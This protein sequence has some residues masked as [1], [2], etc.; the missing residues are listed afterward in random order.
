MKMDIKNMFEEAYKE[1][2]DA[3]FRFCLIRV[4]SR[5]QAL[6]ITQETFLRFWKSLTAGEKI[7]NNKAFLFTIARR[8]VIDWYRKKKSLSL[9]DMASGEED[10]VPPDEETSE[11][12]LFVGIEGRYILDKIKELPSAYREPLYLRFVE[13]LSPPEIAK[14]LG[15]STNAASVRV[16]RGMMELRKIVTDNNDNIKK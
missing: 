7:L 6:D 10:F 12:N 4:S 13:D 14:I 5:E 9:E 3:I 1:E 2:S 8:L 11:E 16:N 15:V